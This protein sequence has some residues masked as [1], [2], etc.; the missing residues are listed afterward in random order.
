MKLVRTPAEPSAAPS[1][2]NARHT[3]KLLVVDDEPD[4]RELTRFNLRGF[5]FADRDLEIIEAASAY[6]AREVL[7]QHSDIAVALVDVVM[8]TD[9]AGL[10]LVEFI[11]KELKNPMVRLIIRTGQPGMAPERQVIDHYDI[12]DYK[13]KTEL[14]AGRL[15]TTVRSALKAYRDLR[16]IDL[17]RVGLSQV[18]DAAPDIYRITNRSLDQFFQGV[19]TQIVGL[20]NLSDSSFISTMGGVIATFED[21]DITVQASSGNLASQER[22]TE[23]RA[24]CA[25]T[26]RTGRLPEGLRKGAYVVPLLVQRKALGFIYIEPTHELN[27]AD[28]NLIT[29]V[30][31]QCSSALEN[32]RLHIDLS[33]SYDHMIDMLA[34]IAEFKDHTTGSHIQRIDQYTRLLAAELGSSEDE[35]LLYGKASR[36]HDVGKIGISDALLCKPGKLDAAE[37][38][39]IKTHTTMGGTILA[40][41]HFLE[42]A[43]EVAL[44]HHERWDGKGYPDGRPSREYQLVTRIVSVVDVFDALVSHRP[45]KKP[46]TPQDAALEIR[47]N[48]GTQF[49]PT[50]VTAFL[51]LFEAGAF[52]A[53]IQSAQREDALPEA[54]LPAIQG[55]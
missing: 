31:Q 7:K 49:D 53:I 35:A 12:D 52:D 33:Q 29:V 9:D 41:D 11:R 14:T 18:L 17:N 5:R 50:I 47:N 38:A 26:I 25:D 39:I 22:F 1:I 3:W 32:L 8:E 2:Q 13:D 23:I 46:W 48:S 36:L 19:L 4:I 28:R 42:L 20:C 16:T 15:Y 30:A 6:E 54:L 44:H 21:S 45:Y 43:R 37:F 40:H 55:A 34:T 27:E 24:Q 51:K 10:R